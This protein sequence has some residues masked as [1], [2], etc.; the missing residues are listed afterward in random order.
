[1]KRQSV[2]LLSAA[3]ALVAVGPITYAANLNQL[4]RQEAQAQAQLAQEEEQYRQTQS[5]INQ[6]VAEMNQLNRDLS[7]ARREIGSTAA[8]IQA[9][10]QHILATEALLSQTQQ[11]LSQ[12]E[13]ALNATTA[14]YQRTVT[15]V[16]LTNDNL[17]HET[18]L[19][20]G[21]LQ[22]IEERGAV[23]YLDV[24]LGARSFQ[25][26]ISRAEL[27][28][29]V[30]AAAAHEVQQ[31]KLEERAYQLAER[32]LKRE[33]IFLSQARAS[34]SQH[35]ALLQAEE[36][37]LA[38]E[39]AHEV[40]LQ[41]QAIQEAS[42]VSTG[43][44]E[45]EQLMRQLE[46][47]RSALAQGMAS[48]KS[49]IHTLVSE[50]QQVLDQ[51]NAGNLNRQGL[52]QAMLPLVTPIADQWGVPPA[53]VIAV[54]TQES[55]GNASAVSSMDAIG[56]MQVEPGTAKNIAAAVG[57]SPAAVLQELYNPEDNV[58]LGTYY[59]HLMLSLFGGNVADALAA[60]NAGPGAV[61]QYGGI[62][63]YPQTQQYVANVM[64]LYRL[65]QT[66]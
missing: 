2:V 13:R 23:G 4:Q 25:D 55:G 3:L 34:I 31:I 36:S 24:I 63:P 14:D 26:F 43:L 54:I 16:R 65:Y 6:T 30:A 17:R 61:K 47:Q 49:R 51:F 15:L 60:Y 64:A 32:N 7:A 56:L 19:L 27:L 66:Y 8:Q 52:Y 48:L 38:R 57:L 29:Q 59:L 5:A 12:T 44:R 33:T 10:N 62:P 9:T 42:T 45:R 21:Q 28:G 20:A 11:Q 53:L 41:D 22:L 46:A 37:L 50:I 35:Q 40:L 39:K 1:M 58:E 18:N